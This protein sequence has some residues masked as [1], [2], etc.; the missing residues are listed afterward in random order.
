MSVWLGKLKIMHKF[1]YVI[2]A[3]VAVI[4]LK[5]SIF[6]Q[7]QDILSFNAQLPNANLYS[8]SSKLGMI[9]KH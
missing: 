6:L 2:Q 9:Y 3:S 1:V 5:P 8:F 7:Q 4:R